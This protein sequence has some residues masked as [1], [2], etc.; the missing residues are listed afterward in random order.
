MLTDSVEISAQQ[1]CLQMSVDVILLEPGGM[2]ELVWVRKACRH[3]SPW[4]SAP[5]KLS[6][7]FTRLGDSMCEVC[8]F[9][10]HRYG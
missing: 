5:S 9:L 3:L 4:L 1:K 2:D 7:V 8:L 10:L 6:P